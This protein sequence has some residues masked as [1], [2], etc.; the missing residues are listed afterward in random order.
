MRRSI[1]LRQMND[2]DNPNDAIPIAIDGPM[3]KS[4]KGGENRVLELEMVFHNYSKSHESNE[5]TK[6]NGIRFRESQ[7]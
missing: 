3:Y 2:E 7:R 1:P 5:V 4:L 6:K